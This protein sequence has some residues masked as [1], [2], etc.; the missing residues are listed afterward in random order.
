MRRY[1]N[2]RLVYIL[3]LGLFLF[4]LIYTLPRLS[5]LRAKVTYEYFKHREFLLELRL[6]K[7]MGRS[8]ATESSLRDLLNRMGLKPESIY[9][10]D[11]G[12]EV[13][14]ELSWRKLPEVVKELE[15]KHIIVNFS[16]V[17]N[18]GKGLFRTR[19]VVK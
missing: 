7:G 5:E 17:D 15:R 14:L 10:S 9:A 2:R 18:T 13:K 6:A 8:A 16:A 3:S 1:I 11:T 12:I 4:F 19:I